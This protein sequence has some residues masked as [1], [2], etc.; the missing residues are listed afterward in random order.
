MPV[1][2]AF[3][4]TGSGPPLV[5][6]H[7]LFGA[8]RNWRSVARRLGARHKVFAVDLRNH[9]GSPWAVPM[10]YAE[11]VDDLAA[12]AAAHRLAHPAL[13]GH[14]LGGKTAMLFALL[15][16]ARV[17]RLVVVDI[18]PVRYAHDHR[19][20]AQAMLRID[21]ETCRSRAEAEARLARDVDDAELRAFLLGN[22]VSGGGGYAWRVNL[23]AIA[24]GMDHLLGFPA[25]GDLCYRGP[26]LFVTGQ[27]SDYVAERHH[28]AIRAFF[29]QARIAVIADAG[30]RVHAE[31][32]ER[33]L[34][35]VE[36]FLGGDAADS[37]AHCG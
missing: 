35:V 1:P 13:L 33:F 24:D 28:P 20:V 21:A 11:T 4:A 15:Y 17:E 29:P 2:L 6:L 12:F 34:A 7:G 3:H 8:A 9:G 22:L 14:S 19:A 10:T 31:Q 16:P 30:H 5:I 36:A 32:A 37:T 25:G 27:R 18:A 26:T 23:S